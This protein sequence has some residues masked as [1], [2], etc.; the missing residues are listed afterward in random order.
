MYLPHPL[1]VALLAGAMQLLQSYW[2]S[3]VTWAGF[4]SWACYFIFVGKPSLGSMLKVIAC[5]SSGVLAS[6]VVILLGSNLLMGQFELSATLAFPVSLGLVATVVISCENLPT[7]DWIPVWF[8]GSA[9]LFG[10]HA[11]HPN[12]LS[13][14]SYEG[15]LIVSSAIIGQLFGWLTVVS[16]NRYATFQHK[17]LSTPE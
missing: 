9:C 15:L 16:R 2:N 4:A 11:D 1:M 3:F 7:L 6:I 17:L 13:T 14:L 10:Y 12:E 5:W 8:I